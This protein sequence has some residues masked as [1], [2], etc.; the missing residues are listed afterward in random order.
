MKNSRIEHITKHS[1]VRQGSL[2]LE[3]N[4]RAGEIMTQ[5]DTNKRYIIVGGGIA[6]VSAAEAIH[7]LQP[8]ADIT[9]ISEEPNLPYFRMSLTRYLAGEVER[10]KLTLHNQQ[11]YLQNLS[12]IHI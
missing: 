1:I 8:E 11:W 3:S 4:M 12:L 6:G 7:A 10:E 2:E 9:L 5:A